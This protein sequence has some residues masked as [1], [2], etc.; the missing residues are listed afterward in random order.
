MNCTVKKHM[1]RSTVRTLLNHSR[2][3]YA[4]QYVSFSGVF[5]P[6]STGSMGRTSCGYVCTAACSLLIVVVTSGLLF[7]TGR[8]PSGSSASTSISTRFGAR[9]S[10]ILLFFA[11]LARPISGNQTRRCLHTSKRSGRINTVIRCAC[12]VILR[13]TAHVWRFVDV[14]DKLKRRDCGIRKNVFYP[15]EQRCSDVL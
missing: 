5:C 15:N 1:S 7:H 9:D 2:S 10:V 13:D 6:V 8:Q 4:Q 11:V 14:Y 12:A 3:G